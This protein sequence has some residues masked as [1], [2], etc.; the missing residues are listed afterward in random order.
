MSAATELARSRQQK[1]RRTSGDRRFARLVIENVSPSVDHGR[2]AAKRVKGQLAEIGVDIFKDGHDLMRARVIYRR[3][4]GTAGEA[5]LSFDFDRDRWYGA[6]PLDQ[7]GTWTFTVEAW[8]DVFGTKLSGLTKKVAADQNVSLELLEIAGLTSTAARATRSK[9]PKSRLTEF[10]ARL[11]DETRSQADRVADARDPELHELLERHLPP[12]DLTAADREY[13]II[14]ERERAAFAA[15]YELFPRSTSNDPRRHG[16]FADAEKALPRLASLGFDV[17][18]LPPIHPIGR[19]FRKGPNNTLQAGPN[20]VG[21]PWAIGG[22]EGGHDA[23]H[24]DLGTIADF[25]RFV[26]AAGKLGME[27]ALDYALQCSPDHPWVK[28]HPDWFKI[29]PDGSIQYAENP[30]KKYQD[31]YPL[32][33]WC[34]DRQNLWNAC[35]DVLLFWA[36]HGVRTFRVDNPH[37][38]PMSFWEWVITEVRDSY[39]DTVF[40]S[41]AF[42]RPKK[43]LYLAKLGFSQSYTYFTWKNTAAELREFITEFSE[44][45]ILEYYRGNLFANTPDILNEYLVKG[46][47]PAFR[48]R[49]IL[50]STLSPLYGIYSGYE[51][52]E[53]VPVREGSEEYMDSEKYQLRPR[54]FDAPGNLDGDIATLNRLRRAFPALQRADNITFLPSENEHILFYRNAAPDGGDEILVA[55]N[56]DPVRAHDSMVHVPVADLGLTNLPAYEVE[57]LLSGEK[58]SWS[59]SRNYVRLDPRERPAHILRLRRQGPVLGGAG[60]GRSTT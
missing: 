16:T 53:N 2:F 23:V 4:D 30:P 50:A 55:V 3:P 38:K 28:E 39:P 44:P 17:V 9:E 40:L 18:Y 22:E 57:D 21:S 56:L 52:S 43:L 59:G 32:D 51:L 58:Y 26:K 19:K 54:D 24:P 60:G 41:E 13:R 46:G 35:R 48:I 1:S 15:W 37:T 34:E 27:V 47:R 8:T 6:F 36:K 42:T 29:R 12:E 25:D 11:S 31:I 20:D 10:A 14:V 49:L 5:P 45:D 33:F 7:L